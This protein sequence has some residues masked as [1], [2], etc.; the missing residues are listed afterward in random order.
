MH[1]SGSGV[2]MGKEASIFGGMAAER[3]LYCHWTMRESAESASPPSPIFLIFK[4]S[5]GI[6]SSFYKF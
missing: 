2:F 1:Y 3:R 5:D 6:L 4:K